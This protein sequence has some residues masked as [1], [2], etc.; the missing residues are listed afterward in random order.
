MQPPTTVCVCN[1]RALPGQLCVFVDFSPVQ[2]ISFSG[3]YV[4]F[5]LSMG[6]FALGIWWLTCVFSRVNCCPLTGYAINYSKS[7]EFEK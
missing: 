2:S 6:G 1:P 4:H 3:I 7:I 5:H